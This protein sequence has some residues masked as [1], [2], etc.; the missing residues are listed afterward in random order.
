MV[1]QVRK[2]VFMPSQTRKI[3]AAVI[4]AGA[5]QLPLN[6]QAMTPEEFLTIFSASNFEQIFPGYSASFY[7]A[8]E[9]EVTST[10][11]SSS[12]CLSTYNEY[13]NQGISD[14]PSYDSCINDLTTAMNLN[15]TITTAFG[16]PVT[17]A[18]VDDG[19]L[20][21][22]YA[23]ANQVL[24]PAIT[25]QVQQATS[26]R[27]ADQISRVLSSVSNMRRRGGPQ[28]TAL[29]SPLSGMAAGGAPAKTNMWL[30][31][32]VDNIKNTYAGGR[33]DGRVT[34]FIGGVDY[35]LNSG[36]V[37]GV[38]LAMDELK[39]NT[40]YNGGN[41]KVTSWMAAP[42]FSYALNEKWVLDASAGFAWGESDVMWRPTGVAVR[43]TQNLT[44]NYQAL[45]LST[46]QWRGE[47]ELSGKIGLIRAEE[48]LDANATLLTPRQKNT[49]TQMRLTGRMGQWMN[50]Y[51]PYAELSYTYDISR[52]D[53][54]RLPGQL[55]DKDGWN[56][57]LGV[58]FFS[59]NGVHGGIL[60]SK[61][62][63][64]DHL[65]SDVLMGNLNYRF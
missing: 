53:Y 5:I 32:S 59:R 52:T 62:F 23:F 63:G 65:E 12:N 39:L 42:Y 35:T 7:S 13:F 57:T 16:G 26:I 46:Q 30:S 15:A 21:M 25:Q 28:R 36:M 33:H 61:Q 10:L 8:M 56:A 44:R 6:A 64:R 19:F 11:Q 34:N 51:E 14:P 1:A 54:N 3:V 4:V 47:T 40:P 38:S 20:T 60:Y 22:Y 55:Q 41:M 49:I 45:N 27:Q 43:A 50:D 29:S 18:D 24:T 17:A 31:A 58:D 48:K 37:V 9:S 2:G